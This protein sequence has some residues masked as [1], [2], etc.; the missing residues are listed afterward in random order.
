M[1]VNLFKNF[2]FWY[3]AGR[4]A[5]LYPAH[6]TFN[7]TILKYSCMKFAINHIQHIGIPVTDIKVSENFYGRLGFVNVMDSSFEYKGGRGVVAMMKRGGM[8]IELYQLPDSELLEI[9]SRKDGHVDHIAFDVDDIG[10]AF[11][12]LKDAGFDIIE[13]DPVFL[14]FWKNG[15][16][17]INVHGPDG[18]RLEFNQVL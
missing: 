14:P 10:Q 9:K 8:I 18:E 6:F 16:R 2:V 12:E 17:Y 4:L 13:E 1:M 15:C 7:K 5:N 11:M 3:S